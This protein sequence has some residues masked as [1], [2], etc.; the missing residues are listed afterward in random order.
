MEWRDKAAETE[1]SSETGE[2]RDLQWRHKEPIPFRPRPKQ[3]RP[4][5]N[6]LVFVVTVLLVVLLVVGALAASLIFMS[7][8][9][10]IAMIAG[11]LPTTY[12]LVTLVSRLSSP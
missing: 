11:L 12:V 10:T 6:K 7:V 4:I 8:G 3:M 1:Q 9:A 2:D 5:R